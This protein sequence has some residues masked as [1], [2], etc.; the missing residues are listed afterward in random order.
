[1]YLMA[2]AVFHV[3]DTGLLTLRHF[4]LLTDL[5]CLDTSKTRSALMS[6]VAEEVQ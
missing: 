3:S 2:L 4:T 1:M 6:R 5:H